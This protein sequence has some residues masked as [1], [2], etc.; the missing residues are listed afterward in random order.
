MNNAKRWQISPVDSERVRQL[1]RAATVPPV[2]A[3]LLLNR[4]L[5]AP[6]QVRSFLDARLS[7]LR[8]PAL[9]PG[10]SD[11]V[12]RI[13]AAVTAR[14]PITVY[15]DYDA[16]GMTATAILMR[17]LRMLGADV[18]YYTPHR[19]E[20]GYG[21]N[22][23]AL[24]QL[25]ASGTKQVITVDCGIASLEQAKTANRLGLELIVTDHHEMADRLPEAA[26]I[27]H[28]RLPG[29]AYPF[30][31]LCGAAVAFKIAWALCQHASQTRRV[32]ERFQEYLLSA[33]GL[34][35]IGTVADVVPL[36]DEN[37][38]IVR[39]GLTSLKAHPTTGIAALMA[40]TRTHTKPRLSAE[41][42]AFQLAPRLN[43]AGRMGQADLA[44]ELM[45][46]ED[47]S[48][49]RGLA[50][51]LDQL[52]SDRKEIEQSIYNEARQQIDEICDVENDPALV[53]AG[54]GWHAGVIGI[55]AGR[56]A[57]KYA[58]P[59]VIIALDALGKSPGTGSARSVNGVDLHQAISGCA[60]HLVSY[61]GHKA[62]A[63]LRIDEAEVSSFRAKFLDQIAG[64]LPPNERTVH[65]VIDAEI[66][67][68]H[69]TLRTLEQIETLAPFG[70]SNPRPILSAL[71]VAV[72]GAVKKVGGGDRHLSF[73]VQGHEVK[74][75]AIAFD[76]A[77]WADALEQARDEEQPIDIVFH[78]FINEFNG[79]RTVQLQVLDWRPSTRFG[80]GQ[81][82]QSASSDASI[83][84]DDVK[85]A[86]TH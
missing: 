79:Y 18:S 77:S 62:A 50:E 71:D 30:D 19:V 55:V 45:T 75:R 32:G 58:R 54:R 29:H 7:A 22:D 67:L 15:G 85:A 11:A 13:F 33:M 43:A 17:C 23:Q 66:P 1:Q 59:C 41:D 52:N 31:G 38:L 86:P 63:G 72:T 35:A 78:P 81:E 60:E 27:V 83:V 12:D 2:V 10:L 47:E 84:V 5:E 21:L 25:A 24:E 40:V 65:L 20:E 56:I 14:H 37:R 51:Y 28:P 53:L 80:P 82:S 26:G 44:I 6:D 42:I 3:Q 4:G 57:E 36:V 74:L 34:A 49:A 69:L 9:L 48:R 39:H 64:E 68:P 76:Q 61:G 73:S 46:T 16:D 70:S 8:D